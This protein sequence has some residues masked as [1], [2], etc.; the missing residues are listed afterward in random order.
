MHTV[1]LGHRPRVNH[2]ADKADS[3]FKPDL[4]RS[5][6]RPDMQLGAFKCLGT[7]GTVYRVKKAAVS[8][9][10]LVRKANEQGNAGPNNCRQP[11]FSPPP[12]PV[13][14]PCE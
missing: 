7:C 9:M 12:P 10:R 3:N 11:G 8:H 2:L 13:C 14:R 4:D 1:T 6:M 5:N